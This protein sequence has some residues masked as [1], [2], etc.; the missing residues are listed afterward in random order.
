M[1]SGAASFAVLC[2]ADC[3]EGHPSEVLFTG[4]QEIYVRE[5]KWASRD[6]TDFFRRGLLNQEVASAAFHA[7]DGA[8][9]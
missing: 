6:E 3:S 5:G 9:E 7:E 1:S 8:T 2:R 4:H